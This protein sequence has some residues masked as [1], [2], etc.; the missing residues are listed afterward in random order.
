[1]T[2]SQQPAATWCDEVDGIRTASVY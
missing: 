2:S 1:L